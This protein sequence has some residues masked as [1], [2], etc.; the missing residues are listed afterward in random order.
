[1]STLYNKNNTRKETDDDE[2]EEEHRAIYAKFEKD[3]SKQ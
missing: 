3:Y 2:E 1:M